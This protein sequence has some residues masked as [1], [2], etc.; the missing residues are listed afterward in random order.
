LKDLEILFCVLRRDFKTVI[1]DV[2]G[3]SS[4][5]DRVGICIGE[6]RIFSWMKLSASAKGSYLILFI[7]YTNDVYSTVMG[8]RWCAVCN[9]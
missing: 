6:L 8:P 5:R 7:G 9:W 1:L 3:V 2:I 4:F